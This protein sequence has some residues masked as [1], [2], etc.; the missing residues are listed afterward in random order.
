MPDLSRESPE[1]DLVMLSFPLHFTWE[2]LQ[3]PLFASMSGASHLAG[4][5]ICLQATL[6]DVAIALVAFWGAA[7]IG[8]R[9]WA[10]GPDW[11]SFGGFL[12]IGVVLTIGLEYLN[13]DILGRW[14]YSDSMPRLPLLGT[15]L[16]PMAQWIAV[17]TIVAWYLHRLSGS[18][19]SNEL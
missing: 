8:G 16:T 9:G 6:G 15:G 11:R 7:L 10:A 1:A 18:R 4:I 17:P 14:S 5:R 13:T 12:A 2:I 19:D 3:A